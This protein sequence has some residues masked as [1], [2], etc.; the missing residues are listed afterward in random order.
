MIVGAAEIAAGVA[1]FSDDYAFVYVLVAMYAAYVI[2][3]RRWL[4]AYMAFFTAMLCLPLVYDGD[5]LSEQVHHIL[6]TFPVF[7]IAALIVAYLRDTL[8]QRERAVPQLRLRGGV[9]GRADPRP[10]TVTARPTGTWP[11]GC[12]EL[13]DREP[14]HGDPGWPNSASAT[15]AS[16]RSLFGLGRADDR[17][18]GLPARAGSR[19]RS[20]CWSRR[21]GVAS[22]LVCWFLPGTGCPTGASTSWPPS[23]TMEILLGDGGRR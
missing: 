23:R 20:S 6:V 1:I 5:D 4:L 22:G 12:D 14:R 10:S 17:S 8:E 15:G 11:A 13:A 18:R 7:L 16:P 19:D 9:A 21:L 3:D 2:R